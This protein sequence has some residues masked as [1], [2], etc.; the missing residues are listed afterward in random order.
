M[1][2]LMLRKRSQLEEPLLQVWKQEQAQVMNLMQ[3][4]Y[5]HIHHP[6][7]PIV[8]HLERYSPLS[9]CEKPSGQY[10]GLSVQSH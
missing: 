8:S 7:S 10:L 1:P 3:E 4:R 6:Q 2:I 5:V 9:P